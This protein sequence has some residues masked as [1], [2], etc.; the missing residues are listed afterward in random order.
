MNTS[1]EPRGGN[2]RF[3]ILGTNIL[4]GKPISSGEWLINFPSKYSQFGNKRDRLWISFNRENLKIITM[5]I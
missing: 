4:K 5:S 1:S 3:L 2:D